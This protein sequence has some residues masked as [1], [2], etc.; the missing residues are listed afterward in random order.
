ML[1]GLSSSYWSLNDDGSPHVADQYEGADPPDIAIDDDIHQ[2]SQGSHPYGSEQGLADAVWRSM[3]GNRNLANDI[4]DPAPA[5]SDRLLVAFARA[6]E[7]MDSPPEGRLGWTAS[8][9][10][11][12][13]DFLVGGQTLGTL[14]A[15]QGGVKAEGKIPDNL[16]KG[17]DEA[18]ERVCRFAL[19]RRLVTTKEKGL[20]GMSPHFIAGGDVV[21]CFPGCS[22]PMLLRKV[23]YEGEE[24]KTYK[25]VTLIYIHGIM[26]GEAIAQAEAEGGLEEVSIW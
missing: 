8:F 14:L 9:V 12:N 25:I 2:P 13:A 16:D 6:L 20:V 18:L 26:E 10:R 17:L 4:P 15:H 3:V 11:R 19:Y 1:D 21:Y 5:E 23:P 22:F 7:Q 24:R